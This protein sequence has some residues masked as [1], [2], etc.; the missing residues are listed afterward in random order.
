MGEA[1]QVVEAAY[2]LQSDASEWLTRLASV[3][4]RPLDQGLGTQAVLYSATDCGYIAAAQG[5][6]GSPSEFSDYVVSLATSTPLE[7]QRYVASLPPGFYTYSRTTIGQRVP[8]IFRRTSASRGPVGVRD[9]V[10]VIAPSQQGFVV[11]GGLAR[12]RHVRLPKRKHALWSMVGGH[13]A[14]GLRLRTHLAQKDR[15]TVEAVLTSSG[16]VEHAEGASRSSLALRDELRRRVLNRDRARRPSGGLDSAEALALWPALVD[17]RLS[18]IDRFESDGKRFVIAVK[19]SSTLRDPRALTPREKE[20]IHLVR[21][22][23]S[24]KE[25]A[26][27]LGS[28]TSAVGTQVSCALAKLGLRSREILLTEASESMSDTEEIHMG[29]VEAVVKATRTRSHYIEELTSAE[30]DVAHSVFLGLSDAAIAHARGT[31]AR[32]VANQIRSIF[33]K[34]SI[35]S[36]SELIVTMIRRGGRGAKAGR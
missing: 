30:R 33:R 27:E 10:A 21:E 25:I 14:A 23:L 19:N 17:G 12:E 26:G 8:G 9:W 36:R 31:S 13:V 29:Q 2:D 18:L 6:A 1:V 7:V 11:L 16:R 32:T 3:A 4:R 28:S 20:V 5:L 24:N 34:L 22:G 35:H 15:L